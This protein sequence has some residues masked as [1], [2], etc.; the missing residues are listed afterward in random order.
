MMFDYIRIGG[1]FKTV[2]GERQWLRADITFA[3][4]DTAIGSNFPVLVGESPVVYRRCPTT[5]ASCEKGERPYL[6]PHIQQLWRAAVGSVFQHVAQDSKLVAACSDIVKNPIWRIRRNSRILCQRFDDLFKFYE[7]G[8]RGHW[9]AR[10]IA[11][12]L[13][14]RLMCNKRSARAVVRQFKM[15][16]ELRVNSILSRTAFRHGNAWT[17][18]EFSS[19]A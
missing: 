7:G 14:L 13:A 2:V 6:S 10:K 8:C 19:L 9:S 5:E 12:I 17:Q 4:I 18:R 1:K 15:R 16:E 11:T 3:V